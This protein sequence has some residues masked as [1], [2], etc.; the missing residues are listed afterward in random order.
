MTSPDD[1]CII[2]AAQIYTKVCEACLELL[3]EAGDICVRDDGA[4][5]VHNNTQ[6]T[7]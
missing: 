2:Y 3:L 5:S 7:S 4:Q 6:I 1:Y